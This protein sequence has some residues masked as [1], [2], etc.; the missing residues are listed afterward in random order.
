MYRNRIIPCLLLKEN[1]L[2]KTIK[3]K[4][5]KY[6]GDPVN[7]IRIFNDKCADELIILDI[8]ASKNKKINFKLLLKMAIQS[9][10][11]LAYGGG[12]NTLKDASKIFKLGFEKICLNSTLRKNL[13]LVKK[14]S[15]IYGTQSVI[16]CI[17][18]KKDKKGEYFIYDHLTGNI[19][20][21]PFE[22]AK[23]VEAL[24]AGEILLNSVDKD[25][26]MNGYD[27]FFISKISPEIKVPLIVS[28]GAGKFKDFK[29][30]I[31]AGA[32]A[33]AAGS[34]FFYYGRHKAVLINYPEEFKKITNKIK[35]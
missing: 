12:I 10:M 19:E 15:Q 8:N 14:I 20:G 4:N 26:R 28:G 33:C 1:K 2:I 29:S 27:S 24:G 34:L 5:E 25:G 16:V 3:F 11:P 22:F 35:R 30:A 7:T 18:I 9:F 23:R 6:I 17:D 13:S 32:D 31:R 21:N